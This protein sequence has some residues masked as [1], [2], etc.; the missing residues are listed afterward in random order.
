MAR[1]SGE[2][3][4]W[5]TGSA[6]GICLLMVG[7]LLALILVQGLGF[8]WPSPLR[9]VALKDGSVFLGELVERE[10]IPAPGAP[11]HHTRHRI[12]L[13]VGTRDLLG[14][15]FRWIDEAKTSSLRSRASTPRGASAARKPAP[16]ALR[17]ARRCH[18]SR[19]PVTR[20]RPRG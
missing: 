12:Q 11:E 16:A 18:I 14:F 10:P 1:S 6:L 4:V 13:K 2:G 19:R 8:F 15:D 20:S 3:W 17:K 5:F 9:R 7:G